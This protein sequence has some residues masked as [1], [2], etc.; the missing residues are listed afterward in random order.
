[1]VA[2]RRGR[3]L[4]ADRGLGEVVAHVA[5]SG[6]DVG[7]LRKAVF[8]HFLNRDAGREAGHHVAVVGEEEV[9]S[10]PEGEPEDQLDS[11]MARAGRVIRPPL[12]LPYVSRGLQV[13]EPPQM[14]ELVPAGQSPG[15]DRNAKIGQRFQ[16]SDLARRF[17]VNFF[18][19]HRF[20]F[21][22]LFLNSRLKIEKF[23][24][25]SNFSI[26]ALPVAQKVLNMLFIGDIFGK[27]GLDL[28]ESLL[29][30]YVQKYSIDFCI[31]N[32]EN[33]VEGKGINEEGAAK[34]F[35]LG[36][37]VITGGNHLWDNWGARKVLAA[38]RNVLRPLNYPPE[39]PGNGFIVYDLGEKGKVGV[40]NLQGRVFMQPLDCPFR[41]ADWA[42]GKMQEQTKVIVLDM[43]AEATAEKVALGWHLDGR[44]TALLGTHTHIQTADARILPRGTAYLTDVGMTGP[45]DSVIGLKK[46]IAIKRCLHQTPYKY[47]LASHDVQVNGVSVQ[48]DSETGKALKI[49]S[50]VYPAFS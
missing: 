3:I 42:V 33:L 43:H 20:L 21:T 26:F 45:Y 38:N 13:D 25:N 1:M 5:A 2:R 23:L 7:R 41:K 47:E 12:R 16:R 11:L 15:V 9:L 30:S 32:G 44:I 40:L 31:A 17:R 37:H 27:P 19:C 39:N 24:V 28:V 50:F 22:G 48:A 35:S 4:D 6:R 18:S 46:E 36:V 14:E 10:L 49:E 29:K 34:V 8:N